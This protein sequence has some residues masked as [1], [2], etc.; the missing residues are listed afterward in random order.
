MTYYQ[1]ALEIKYIQLNLFYATIHSGDMEITID[2]WLLV[3]K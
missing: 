3:A 2:R 1:L